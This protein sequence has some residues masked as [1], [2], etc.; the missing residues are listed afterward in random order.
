[1]YSW[2]STNTITTTE[3]LYLVSS[4]WSWKLVEVR[5]VNVAMSP[6]NRYYVGIDN[7]CILDKEKN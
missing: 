2:G 5:M 4:K 1:M 7:R 3:M 6:H